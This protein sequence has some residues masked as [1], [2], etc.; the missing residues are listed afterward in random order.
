MGRAYWPGDIDSMSRG[1]AKSPL[2]VWA[3]VSLAL[4]TGQ[5]GSFLSGD[6][7]SPAMGPPLCCQQCKSGRQQHGQLYT[8]NSQHSLFHRQPSPQRLGY[9]RQWLVERARFMSGHEDFLLALVWTE[10]RRG[11][12]AASL[13]RYHLN[14]IFDSSNQTLPRILARCIDIV[15]DGKRRVDARERLDASERSA[16]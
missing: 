13:E 15:A 14:S 2:V 7:L 12:T 10:Y 5:C 6:I 1:V 4:E 8:D 3:V 9:G 11:E 16:R